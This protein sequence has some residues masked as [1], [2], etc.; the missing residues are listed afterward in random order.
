M[1]G[2]TMV[3]RNDTDTPRRRDLDNQVLT[4]FGPRK[5]ASIAL[6]PADDVIVSLANAYENQRARQVTEWEQMRRQMVRRAA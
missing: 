1:G 2:T 3:N 5:S 4:G 6:P